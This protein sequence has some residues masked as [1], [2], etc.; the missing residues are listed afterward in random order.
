MLNEKIIRLL[1]T[2]TFTILTSQIAFKEEIQMP[3]VPSNQLSGHPSTLP[4]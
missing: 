3:D 2:I 4:T 1:R